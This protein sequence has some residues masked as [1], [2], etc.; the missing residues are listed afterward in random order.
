MHRPGQSVAIRVDAFP[1]LAIR[2]NVDRLQ[3]GTGS[4]FGL[5]T[6]ENATR[7]FMK[8]VRRVPVKVTFDRPAEALRWISS[9]FRRNN[10]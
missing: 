2:G 7:N 5:L 1:D 6:P 3:R 8:L 9:G 10:H 4:Q